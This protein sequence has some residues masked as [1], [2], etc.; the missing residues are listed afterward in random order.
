MEIFLD[1]CLE[2]ILGIKKI[3]CKIMLITLHNDGKSIDHR[4]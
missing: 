3:C 4:I 2:K 1:I